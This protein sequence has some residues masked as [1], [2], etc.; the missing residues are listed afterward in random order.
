[1]ASHTSELKRSFYVFE[2]KPDAQ[3]RGP[4]HPSQIKDLI[5][6]GT[7]TT[8]CQISSENKPEWVPLNEHPIKP[9]VA[10]ERRTLS[11]RDTAEKPVETGKVITAEELA[12]ASLTQEQRDARERMAKIK[13]SSGDGPGLLG[14]LF[15][16]VFSLFL[17]F[18][19]LLM[20]FLVTEPELFTPHWTDVFFPITPIA[21]AYISIL[22]STPDAGMTS[23][24][25]VITGAVLAGYSMASWRY[26]KWVPLVVWFIIGIPLTILSTQIFAFLAMPIYVLQ[27]TPLGGALVFFMS[28]RYLRSREYA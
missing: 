23:L 1:M 7:L 6:A 28:Y 3:V 12:E 26:R 9:I 2:N 22:E 19:Y 14:L 16:L 4:F 20:S 24:I 27:R 17:T 11:L 10:P 18:Q 8:D 13:P 21:K 5:D 25:I 15:Q